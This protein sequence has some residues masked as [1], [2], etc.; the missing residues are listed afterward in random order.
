M[1]LIYRISYPN[2]EIYVGKDLTGT[3][4][5][6]GSS[7][8]DLIARDFSDNEKMRFVVI[9][10]I[11]WESAEASDREVSEREV[12]RIR[13]NR[14]NDPFIGYNHWPSLRDTGGRQ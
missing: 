3:L 11:L 10:E 12:A 5:Y 7:D 4:T 8:P 1:K 2:G 6:F 13:E 9:K 14:S